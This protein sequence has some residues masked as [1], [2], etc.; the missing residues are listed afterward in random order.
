MVSMEP[1]GGLQTELPR[2]KPGELSSGERGQTELGD[3]EPFSHFNLS[4]T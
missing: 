2:A 3:L 1:T 4:K